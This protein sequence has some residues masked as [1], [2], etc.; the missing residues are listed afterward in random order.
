MGKIRLTL[1]L[2][3]SIL[4]TGCENRYVSVTF[5]DIW[6]DGKPPVVTEYNVDKGL[7]EEDYQ[8]GLS[9]L[10]EKLSMTIELSRVDGSKD[11]TP[12]LGDVS[13]IFYTY[14]GERD[15]FLVGED[16]YRFNIKKVTPGGE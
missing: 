11:Q 14:L 9:A 2:S 16:T 10:N 3:L 7:I 12:I 8:K 15:S 5:T 1:L 6:D 4:M 13:K